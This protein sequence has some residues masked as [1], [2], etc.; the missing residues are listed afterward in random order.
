M[1]M[2]TMQVEMVMTVVLYICMHVFII[3]ICIT[4]QLID[5][6][7][8]FFCMHI[9]FRRLAHGLS[10]MLSVIMGILLLVTSSLTSNLYTKYCD[11]LKDHPDDPYYDYPAECGDKQRTFLVLP[12]FGYCTLAVWVSLLCITML[13]TKLIKFNHS[14]QATAYIS[15]HVLLNKCMF[16]CHLHLVLHFQY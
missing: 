5:N 11:F 10:I 9:Q 13:T 3:Y 4:Q 8:G 7:Q 6:R 15:Y 14:S 16:Y 1:H 12:F 2:T